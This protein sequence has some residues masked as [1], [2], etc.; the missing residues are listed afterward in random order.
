MA[1][2]QNPVQNPALAP[3]ASAVPVSPRS[4]RLYIS[5]GFAGLILCQMIVLWLLLPSRNTV[6]EQA[7]SDPPPDATQ[8][9][10]PMVEVPLQKDP[11]K[12]TQ[13]RGD[14]KE[15]LTLRMH[16][17][18]KKKES[19]KFARQY[20]QYTQRVIDRVGDVLYATSR[21]ERQEE[22]LHVLK[23]KSKRGINEALG[24]PLVQQVLIS[25]YNFSTE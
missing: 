19:S 22:G 21:A 11:F 1:K 24:T 18:V 13:L 23:E 25:E 4:Y 9:S 3:D 2:E 20:E 17:L 8:S 10:E 16:V 7:G 6:R 12:V 14:E 5:L 15:N